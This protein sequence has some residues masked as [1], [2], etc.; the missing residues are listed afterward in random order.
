MRMHIFVYIYTYTYIY[1]YI[2]IY[3]HIY[4]YIYITP[5]SF[6][7]C[8]KFRLGVFYFSPNVSIQFP[9]VS[10][11]R[12]VLHGARDRL[13]PL[14]MQLFGTSA[15]A[16]RFGHLHDAPV[17][18]HSCGR[19]MDPSGGRRRTTMDGSTGG[20]RTYGRAMDERQTNKKECRT[21]TELMFKRGC[22]RED[23]H[24]F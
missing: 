2:C 20:R 8:F 19:Q 15:N 16:K 7:I 21:L 4:I 13:V 18:L 10:V 5:C 22:F 12:G 14:L 6:W 9:R 1:I 23:F 17:A 24:Q 11:A 3:E